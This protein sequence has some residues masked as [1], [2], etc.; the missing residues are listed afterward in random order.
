M[1]QTVGYRWL[2]SVVLFFYIHSGSLNFMDIFNFHTA[3]VASGECIPAE[4]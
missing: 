1:H 2:T 4:Y 3:L